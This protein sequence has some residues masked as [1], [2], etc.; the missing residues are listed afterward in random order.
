MFVKKTGFF[1]NRDYSSGTQSSHAF[2]YSY[3]ISLL[4]CTSR[5]GGGNATAYRTR[6]QNACHGRQP[7]IL[8][9]LLRVI[10]K[11]RGG[12]LGSALQA[13]STRLNKNS[14]MIVALPVGRSRAVYFV[15][16]WFRISVSYLTV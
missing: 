5:Y 7:M 13:T 8:S 1:R 16:T 6:L 4:A 12:R 2:L 14:A 11:I 10:G 9:S 3:N 15:K